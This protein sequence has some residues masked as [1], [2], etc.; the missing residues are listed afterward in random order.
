MTQLS[1]D[2]PV[3]LTVHDESP[4]LKPYLGELRMC[5]SILFS[6]QRKLVREIKFI[7]ESR[8]WLSQLVAVLLRVANYQDHIFILNHILRYVLIFVTLFNHKNI[9]I[10]LFIDF[11]CRCPAGVGSWASSFI[12]TPL[13]INSTDSP[14]A[15]FQIN[16][17]L[18]IFSAILTPVHSREE[19]LEDLAVKNDTCAEAFWVMVDSD[20]ED[21]DNLPIKP[22]KENDLVAFLNQLP[23]DDLFRNVLLI[24]Q[25]NFQVFLNYIFSHNKFNS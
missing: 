2:A 8:S 3:A 10:V 13:N 21:D 5:I 12:Q 7:K 14:F 19:F 23:L 24:R 17:V 4:H 18:T 6:F 22:L 16:H 15:N 25:K 20:G 1:K 11:N 9:F